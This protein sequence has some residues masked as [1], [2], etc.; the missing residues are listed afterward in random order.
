MH[1]EKRRWDMIGFLR[2]K[3]A[4]LSGFLVPLLFFCACGYTFSGSEPFPGNVKEIF[5]SQVQDK[6]GELGLAPQLRDDLI[7]TLTRNRQV[8]AANR[9]EKADAF[10]ETEVRS[11][12]E[13]SLTRTAKDVDVERRLHMTV[14]FVLKGADGMIL[15]QDSI[16]EHEDFK[17]RSD[18][19]I[20]ENLR[21][22]AL[23][24][25]SQRMAERVVERMGSTF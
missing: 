11:V 18:K 1:F 7:Y 19:A 25:L 17:V 10:L 23:E 22:T 24:T 13:E 4:F 16:Q 8:N 21:R 15:W 20:T 14:F 9:M 2:K 6:V 3:R 12:S 5:V